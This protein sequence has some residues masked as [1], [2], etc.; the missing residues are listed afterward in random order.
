MRTITRGSSSSQPSGRWPGRFDDGNDDDDDDHRKKEIASIISGMID[1]C[2]S[3]KLKLCMRIAERSFRLTPSPTYRR[4]FAFR[5]SVHAT[6]RTSPHSAIALASSF[7]VRLNLGPSGR[8]CNARMSGTPETETHIS[9][10]YLNRTTKD[11]VRIRSGTYFL[12]AYIDSS[13]GV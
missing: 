6:A 11:R 9:T 13:H 3:P 10:A 5:C 7:F 1:R 8:T 12:Y 4:A 2:V